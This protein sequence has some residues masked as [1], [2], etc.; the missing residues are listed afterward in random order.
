MVLDIQKK[1]KKKYYSGRTKINKVK[2]VYVIV[3]KF[4]IIK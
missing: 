2:V 3:A 4:K 1:T